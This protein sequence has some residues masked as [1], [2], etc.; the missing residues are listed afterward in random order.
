MW[1]MFASWPKEVWIVIIPLLAAAIGWPVKKLWRF[2]EKRSARVEQ[3]EISALELVELLRRALDK[4]RIRENGMFT[5]CDL[6]ITALELALEDT[7]D[8]SPSIRSARDR[9][10]EHLSE[11]RLRCR[12]IE[13]QAP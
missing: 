8:P 5:A 1:G 7:H 2:F 3:R 9:A 10:L 4:G 11:A 6:L 12:M 13:E